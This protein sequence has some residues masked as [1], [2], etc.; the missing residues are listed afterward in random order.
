MTKTR[1]ESAAIEAAA[2]YLSRKGFEIIA[3]RFDEAADIVAEDDET[4]VFVKVAAS[5]GWFDE[6]PKA[7]R[8]KFERAMLR[9]FERHHDYADRRIRFDIVSIMAVTEDRAVIRHCVDCVS[10]KP[11]TNLEW[12]ARNDPAALLEMIGAEHHGWLGQL[13]EDDVECGDA[14]EQGGCDGRDGG[15]EAR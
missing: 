1:F 12:L 9:F 14:N 15:A 13:H 2:R 7:H 6:K 11:L 10:K 8:E 4:V 3:R 5:H